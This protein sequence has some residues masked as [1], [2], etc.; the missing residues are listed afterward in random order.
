MRADNCTPPIAINVFK[1]GI[2][3]LTSIKGLL[4]NKIYKVQNVSSNSISYLV[5]L[6]NNFTILQSIKLIPQSIQYNLPPLDSSYKI[7]IIGD[8]DIYIS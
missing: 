4:K 2:Y 7:V 8:G 3:C 5:L 1:E 6:D